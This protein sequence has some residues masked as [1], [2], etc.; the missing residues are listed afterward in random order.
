MTRSRCFF[1]GA[2]ARSSKSDSA[3]LRA[4]RHHRECGASPRVADRLAWRTADAQRNPAPE[5]SPASGATKFSPYVVEVVELVE[6][7]DD[8]LGRTETIA[9]LRR[10]LQR[11]LVDDGPGVF[12]G[13]TR[14]ADIDQRLARAVREAWEANPS[15][16]APIRFT[17]TAPVFDAL[18]GCAPDGERDL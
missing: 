9:H 6:M 11:E 4:F 13:L 17:V 2:S 7:S 15:E 16:K 14:L 3:F 10:H 8:E 5:P 18:G 1:V 12:L